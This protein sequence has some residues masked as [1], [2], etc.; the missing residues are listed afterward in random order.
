VTQLIRYI[1]VL[2]LFFTLQ[3]VAEVALSPVPEWI[4]TIQPALSSDIPEQDISNGIY[5]LLAD[6]QL[7]VPA[8]GERQSFE[9]YASLVTSSKGLEKAGQ[10]SIY[11]DPTYQNI[12]LHQLNIIRN[13]NSVNRYPQARI[14]LVQ[15]EHDLEKLLY[16]GET[17]LNIVL[18][19]LR[20]GDIVQYSYS[21]TGDNPVF[22]DNFATSQQLNWTVPLQQQHWRLMWQK[23]TPLQYQFSKQAL[24]LQIS[25]EADS[26]IYS[27]M[28]H[29]VAAI[30]HEDD[31]PDWFSPYN[32]LSLSNSQQWQNIASWGSSLFEP[33]IDKSPAVLAVVAR[34]QADFQTPE[35]QVVAALQFVQREIRYLGIELGESSHKPATAGQVLQQ[36]YGD[37]KDKSILLVSILRQ[38]GLHAV[39]VLVNTELH[40]KIAKRLPSVGVFDHAMVKL[41][42]NNSIYWLDPTRSFQAGSLQ[43]LY[44]PDYGYAL[45]LSDG[46]TGLTA[47]KSATQHTKIMIDET[48]Q[49]KDALTQ[50][51]EYQVSTQYSG[52]D[53]E[54]LRSRFASNSV[55]QNADGYVQFYSRYYPTVNQVQPIAN[56]DDP[57]TGI[58]TVN[59]FY[60]IADFWQLDN[61]DNTLNASFYSNG[62]SSYLQSP[63][64]AASRSQP[65][66][67]SHPVDITQT[68]SVTLND[69]D[70]QF[71]PKQL[72]ENNPFFQYQ[73]ELL[74]DQNTKRLTLRYQYKSLTDHITPEQRLAYVAAVNRSRNDLNLNIFQHN[75]VNDVAASEV[76]DNNKL[77][78]LLLAVYFMLW[79][80]CAALWLL[81]FNGQKHQHFAEPK[82]RF[83]LTWIL[84]FSIYGLYWCVKNGPLL[85]SIHSGRHR[86]ASPAEPR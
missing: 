62:I 83:Y 24:S 59:E 84:S 80:L 47:M 49:L 12:Q 22:A 21:I 45:E 53:A 1:S 18:P 34:L 44:Q 13:G 54:R 38:L 33:A 82:I 60:Q 64:I 25:S 43:S 55:S 57:T 28:Q 78:L 39:P 10:I 48:F 72:E 37:C 30:K 58:F 73:S 23:P 67:L 65:F 69:L 68:I 85:N 5:Y 79:V 75:N 66:A 50:A 32:I 4:T 81:P 11:F 52:L 14:N 74:F 61:D 27:L 77:M 63:E 76:N 41:E 86:Q 42:F 31:T 71:E 35:Q 2:A 8:T 46:V 20:V 70:W 7:R 6:T 3:S 29:N 15:T 17:A 9:H 56:T 26:T 51:A 36:R 16:H 40:N 19:D